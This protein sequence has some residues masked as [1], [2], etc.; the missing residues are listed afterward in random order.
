MNND[1]I[2]PDNMVLLKSRRIFLKNSFLTTAIIVISGSAFFGGASA[3]ETFKVVQEDLFP[4]ATK[5]EIHSF[6]YLMLIL[7]HSRIRDDEKSFLRNGVQWL[8]EEAVSQ[9]KQ[10]YTKLSSNQ[11]QIILQT[12]AK[13]QWGKKWIAKMLTYI[14]E[15]TLGDPIYGAN[16]NGLGWNWLEHTSGLPRPKKGYL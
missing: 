16:T 5:L 13:K 4:H 9:Y 3:L 11:R 14:M 12:V 2:A 8:H 10:T 15:A 1:T 6:S 7:N